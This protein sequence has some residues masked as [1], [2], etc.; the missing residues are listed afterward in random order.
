[1]TVR[2]KSRAKG[3]SDR[4]LAR[5]CVALFVGKLETNNI[6]ASQDHGKNSTNQN[7]KS[8]SGRSVLFLG[9]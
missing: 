3:D 6:H 9:E 2:E 8:N 1:M 5:S 4:S 7:G